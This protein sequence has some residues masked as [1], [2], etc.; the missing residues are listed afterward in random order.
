KG[1]YLILVDLDNQKAID[2]F[3]T[4]NGIKIP[5][6][7]LA[8]SKFCIVEQHKDAPDK[9]H[10]IFYASHPFPKKSSDTTAPGT[11]SE[12]LTSNEIPAIEVKGAGQHGLLFCTPSPHKNGFNYE[13]I[14][15]TELDNIA[16]DAFETHIDN[17]C[18]KYGIPY[19]NA[20]SKDEVPISE[21]FKEDTK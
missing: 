11:L 17:I 18:S 2:E 15:N 14:G 12:K 13:I 19:L 10:I 8:K 16:T 20:N 21:L 5:L 6:I 7:G 1:L 9:A 4:R 3:C